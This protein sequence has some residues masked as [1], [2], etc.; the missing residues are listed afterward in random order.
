V[1]GFYLKLTI[2]RPS[3]IL[4][5]LLLIIFHMP[6]VVSAKLGGLI[7]YEILRALL[8]NKLSMVRMEKFSV[9]LCAAMVLMLVY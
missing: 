1:K 9:L 2:N 3:H 8:N 5:N 4:Y 6:C 7:N